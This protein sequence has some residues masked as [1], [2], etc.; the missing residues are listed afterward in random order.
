M[1]TVSTLNKVCIVLVFCTGTAI[2]SSAQT[3]TN[4]FDFD[5]ADGWSV[6]APLIEGTDGNFYGTT[7]WGGSVT[8]NCLSGCGTVFKIT[9]EGTLTT[10]YNFGWTD[11]AS[12]SA[13]L[14]QAADGNFY[15]TTTSGGT[16]CTLGCGTVFKITPAGTL[17]TLYSFDSTD[18]AVP[19]ARLIQATDG[20]FYGTTQRGGASDYGTVFEISPAGALTTLHSFTLT[21]GAYPDAGLIQAKDGNFYGT[22]NAGGNITVGNPNGYGTVFKMTPMGTLTVLYEFCSLIGCKD[23]ESPVAGL[24]QAADGNFYGTTESGGNNANGY[25][26]V[27]KITSTGTLT[28]LHKF[29]SNPDGVS[30]SAPL[31]EAADGNFYGTT[32]K[33]G[34][35]GYGSIF[36]I[37]AGGT[38]AT[39][40]S[41]NSTDGGYPDAG[42]IQ[43]TDGSFYG[44]T[45]YGGIP[46]GYTPNGWGTVFRL[47]VAP[48]VTL[49]TTLL[50]FGNEALNETSTAKGVTLK[51]NGTALLTISG[52]TLAGSFSISSDKCTGAT[53]GLGST[54]KITVTFTPTVLGPLTGTLTFADNAANSPQSVSLSGTGVDPATLAPA[55]V[56]YASQK[57]GTTSTAKAFTL[58]NNQNVTLTNIAV[59]TTG[60]FA[61]SATTCSTSL[62]TKGKCTISVTFTP[63]QIG[64][65][66]GELTVS[67]SASNSP[68]ISNLNGTGK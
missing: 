15:G 34:T 26:T 45:E 65:R 58:T 63:T 46:N 54:C 14:I 13:G 23:G 4:L 52:V 61:V 42:L 12:P 30:P 67:D 39:V 21:D 31:I 7:F 24:I 22:T 3:F 16:N 57:V 1:T 48:A 33:G 43:T 44:T 18:G 38:L 53:L 64:V 17:T 28:T 50:K 10:L 59:S 56:T 2:F 40:H 62:T 8:N 32:W 60:D 11:G 9:P 35:S 55:T 6:Q 66:A 41:F 51:N 27:F 49:S 36:E 47:A 19:V 68:Q 29:K 5:S 20:N 37:N 25:G